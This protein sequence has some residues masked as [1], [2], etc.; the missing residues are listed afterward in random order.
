MSGRRG[1]PSTRH[2]QSTAPEPEPEPEP[3]PAVKLPARQTRR[4]TKRTEVPIEEMP[5]KRATRSTGVINDVST[6]AG[7]SPIAQRGTRRQRRRSMESIATRDFDPEDEILDNES[8]EVA[9]EEESESEPNEG[10]AEKEPE[11]KPLFH[12]FIANAN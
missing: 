7:P 2:L 4:I 8:K 10:A 3:E 11:G 1:R 9:E 12:A 5:A 6:R